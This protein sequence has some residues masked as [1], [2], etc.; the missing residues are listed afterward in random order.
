VESNNDLI[1]S[2]VKEDSRFETFADTDVAETKD[3]L[4]TLV[5]AIDNV[6]LGGIPLTGR[7]TEVFGEPSV[8]KST[9]VG[10]LIGVAQ[11]M[12]II[13][14]Y[15]DSE[16]PTSR[17]R[18]E[19]LGVDTS[20]ILTLK[21]EKKRDGTITPV[22]IEDVFKYMISTLAKIHKSRPNQIVLFIWDTV[23][24]TMSNFVANQDVG[25]QS[26]GNQA[27]ALTEGVRKLNANLIANNGCVIALNQMRADI[28]GNPMYAK[29]KT[30]GGKGW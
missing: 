6:M 30:V 10:N 26:V 17:T 28:G 27:R 2:L 8:G 3:W 15:F 9:M 4:P 7:I 24:M 23:A 25:D 12:G 18:L 29:A 21:P 5:P 14:I 1:A 11:H 20:H 13:P 19:D 22:T 16:G